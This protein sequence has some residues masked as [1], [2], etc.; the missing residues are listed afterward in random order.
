MS[1]WRRP[2]C[3]FCSLIATLARGEVA[4]S[5]LEAPWAAVEVSR[6]AWQQA[7]RHCPQAMKQW[8]V[9]M[10]IFALSLDARQVSVKAS[11]VLM[12]VIEGSTTPAKVAKTPPDG[13]A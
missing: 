1:R 12:T 4:V 6:T 10:S 2:R 5:W 11:E 3:Y 9:L 13:T 7:L 8:Q